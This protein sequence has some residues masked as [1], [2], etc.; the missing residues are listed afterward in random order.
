MVVNNAK[1]LLTD[2]GLSEYESLAYLS[3]L[4]CQPATAYELSKVSGIPS[5]KIY[6]TASRLQDKRLIEPVAADTGRG[7]ALHRSGPRRLR[8]LPPRGGGAQDECP[9]TA[10]TGSQQWARS[11]LHLAAGHGEW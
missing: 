10:T 11:R 8:R 1:E 6:E 4:G 3:L 9:R 7:P 5:S 2:L